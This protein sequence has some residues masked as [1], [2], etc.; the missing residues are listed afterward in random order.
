MKKACVLFLGLFFLEQEVQPV[1]KTVIKSGAYLVVAHAIVA[2]A[3]YD[4]VMKE[5]VADP[6]HCYHVDMYNETDQKIIFNFPALKSVQRSCDQIMKK[7]ELN[8]NLH[9][10]KIAEIIKIVYDSSLQH[11]GVHAG[12][13][14]VFSVIPFFGLVPSAY[15][16]YNAQNLASTTV[17]CAHNPVSLKATAK[18]TYLNTQ[19]ALVLADKSFWSEKP[20][21]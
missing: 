7:G 12:L 6:S 15:C 14:L 11:A 16:A 17:D 9:D 21:K 19:R 1:L 20:K 10:Q 4:A 3:N 2:L 18:R 8:D 13:G 5:E